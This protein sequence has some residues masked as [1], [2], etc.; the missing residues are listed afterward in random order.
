MTAVVAAPM[1]CW[2]FNRDR[3]VTD[4]AGPFNSHIHEGRSSR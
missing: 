2:P 3:I 1:G 4:V